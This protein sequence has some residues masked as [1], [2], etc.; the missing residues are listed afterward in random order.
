MNLEKRGGEVCVRPWPWVGGKAVRG[1][2]ENLG[3]G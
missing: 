1:I 2:G 3:R